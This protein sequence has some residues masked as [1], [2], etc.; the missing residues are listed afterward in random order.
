VCTVVGAPLALASALCLGS[1]LASPGE[2]TDSAACP[3][4][5]AV[6]EAVRA[7]LGEASRDLPAALR[8]HVEDRGDHFVVTLGDQARRFED[9]ARRC[10]DRARKAAVY[11]AL[12]L[13]PPLVPEPVPAPARPSA[14][15]TRAVG[16]RLPLIQLDLAGEFS[17]TPSPGGPAAT[18]GVAARLFVGARWVGGIIGIDAL[19]PSTVNLVGTRAR[20]FRVPIYLGARGRLVLRRLVLS[21]DL[22]LS[23]GPIV[24]EGQDLPQALRETRLELG[25]GAQVRGEYWVTARLAPFVGFSVDGLPRP[26]Q[27]TVPG[28]GV[29]GETPGIWL[30]ATAGLAVRLR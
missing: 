13:Q 15:S 5:A 24:T 11:L 28:V 22:A 1:A 17:A 2:A 8:A 18:G 4:P 9:P 6:A 27:L 19:A 26:Y 16:G 3:A 25:I 29:V 30:S 21:L 20:I 12:L 10:D 23:L 7:T 14:P